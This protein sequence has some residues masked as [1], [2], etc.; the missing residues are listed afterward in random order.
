M[1]I[2]E[3]IFSPALMV[4][5]IVK[6]LTIGYKVAKTVGKGVNYVANRGQDKDEP[7]PG[8]HRKDWQNPRGDTGK[9]LSN[10]DEPDTETHLHHHKD[11]TTISTY[12]DG[13]PVGRYNFD[14]GKDETPKKKR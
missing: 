9:V 5:R 10:D 7:V 1:D 11:G 3:F 8:L 2:F 13:K 6:S 12:K 14:T 4:G